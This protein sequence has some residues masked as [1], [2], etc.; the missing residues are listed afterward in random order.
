M[1]RPGQKTFEL[2]RGLHTG[3]SLW[4]K[5]IRRD[6]TPLWAFDEIAASGEALAIPHLTSFLLHKHR[7]VNEAA[8]RAIG[9]LVETLAVEDFPQ[10]DEDCRSEWA[11][12]SPANSAWCSLKPT[13]LVHLATLPNPVAVLGVASF[14]GSGFIR[15]AAVRELIKLSGGPELPF[16]LVRLNDWVGA[17][18]EVACNAARARIRVD[19]VT[20]FFQN[21][22]LV[23]RLRSCGRT[24][25]EPLV[26][27]V[28]SLLQTPGASALLRQGFQSKDR[29]L[30]RESFRMAIASESGDAKELLK[31]LL[32]DADPILRLWAARNVLSRLE[33]VE[34]Q[35]A[36]SKLVRDRFMPVRCVALGLLAERSPGLPP[37]L[38]DALLDTHASVRSLARYLIHS[39]KPEFDFASAY[40]N[41]LAS[42]SPRKQCA[43]VLGLG[44]TGTPTDADAILPHLKS[45]HV[46][47]RKAAIR[48]LAALDRERFV[49]EF[50]AA[51]T[52]G[53]PGIS[54]EATRALTPGV[55]LCKDRIRPLFPGEAPPH[56]RKNLFKLLLRLPFWER[57]IFLF[58][59]LRDRDAHLVE[60][61]RRALHDW[62]EQS[63]SIASGPGR[64]EVQQIRDALAATKGMLAPHQVRELEFA[65]ETYS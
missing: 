48:T 45:A 28:I 8:A 59:A 43:A 39:E 33:E 37:P 36:L 14:H 26:S 6:S 19:Y 47:T 24:E 29:W 46:G 30:R 56:V 22:R 10:M 3:E 16:L 17:V 12:Q 11:Y 35:A 61:A 32:A 50:F 62:I 64:S 42:G 23:L 63:R 20:Q 4:G 57:G 38:V 65:F 41:S 44:E 31:E 53:H 55:S 18:R 2:L 49:E 34:L 27:A 25:H 5:L 21:L 1:K 9:R 60:L 58:E 13:Q 7:E 52:G 51:L 54:N 15:E 40:R